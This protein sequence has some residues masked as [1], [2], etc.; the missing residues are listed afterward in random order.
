MSSYSEQYIES[1]QNI[2]DDYKTKKIDHLI[3]KDL[4]NDLI[5]DIDDQIK[6]EKFK[7][8]VINKE[9][10]Y[11]KTKFIK[12]DFY[13]YFEELFTEN[14]GDGVQMLNT[15]LL[16]NNSLVILLK[17]QNKTGTISISGEMGD[18]VFDNKSYS[19]F[20][21]NGNFNTK[22]IRNFMNDI[23]DFINENT[24]IY[25]EFEDNYYREY[26][27][28]DT[29]ENEKLHKYSYDELFINFAKFYIEECSVKL[30]N[31]FFV[32]S[33]NYED[34]CVTFNTKII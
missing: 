26:D 29:T 34:A 4:L 2:L 22:E 16:R 7:N 28:D 5:L 21:R 27:E 25:V 23:K 8:I 6:E 20:N 1:L 19:T 14:V 15:G 13:N 9:V 30:S 17:N 10:K 31:I 24:Q 3:L 33:I 12:K 18:L 32:F 11:E